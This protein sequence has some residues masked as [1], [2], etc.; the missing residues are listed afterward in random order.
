M[1]RPD[2]TLEYAKSLF[3]YKDGS[4][5]W[6]VKKATHIKIGDRV[7]SPTNGYESVYVDGK[8]WRIHRLVFLMHNG[9]FPK[10]VDHINGNR[11]DNRAENL[12]DA[13]DSQNAHNAKLRR[14]NKTGIKGV[15]W[16]SDRC[17]WAARVNFKRKTYQV[18]YFEDIE[19]AELAVQMAREKYH[20]AYANHGVN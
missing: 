4:L 10:M 20:G 7:G 8:N 14:D 5:F 17:K 6:K 19:L 12:R 1:Q 2:M 9:Y 16:N 3:E 11:L 13:D 18:G 15:S